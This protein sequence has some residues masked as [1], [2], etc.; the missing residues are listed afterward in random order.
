LFVSDPPEIRL[1]GVQKAKGL[2]PVHLA[3]GGPED[4][5]VTT[6]C[7][8]RF[9]PGRFRWSE[10][11]PGCRTCLRR[12]DDAA[13]ISSA[14]FREDAGADFLALAVER[15]RRATP[16]R[17]VPEH[18][19]PRLHV[20]PSPAAPA[21][22]PRSKGVPVLVISGTIGAGKTAV[23]DEVSC[24]LGEQ[25]ILHALIDLDHLGNIIPAPDA[26][27]LSKELAMHNL[28]AIWPNYRA[29]G[30]RRAVI[31]RVIESRDELAEFR[32]AIPNANITV[33]ELRAAP[34][35]LRSRVT[36]REAGAM[37]RELLRRSPQLD[38]SLRR[39]SAA[40]HVVEND[41][42]PV[43]AVAEEVLRLA[44]WS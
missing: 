28:A 1:R 25:G 16:P 31:A 9:D 10:E 4:R 2:A 23:A 39:A 35:T 20:V 29:A 21:P 26:D 7:S 38:R 42:R 14:F 17:V 11:E 3:V 32:R 44:G 6:L 18:K 40:D 12:R 37:R 13:R 43:R 15:S 24:L 36:A 34:E 19:A 5:P 8:I 22:T 27:P 33:V 41:S 30:V